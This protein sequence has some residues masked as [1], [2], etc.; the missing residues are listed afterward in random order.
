MS[1]MREK[2]G[3]SGKLFAFNFLESQ[4]NRSVPSFF[5]TSTTGDEYSEWLLIIHCLFSRSSTRC[6]NSWLSGCGKEL[7]V[8]SHGISSFNLIFI[9]LCS[10]LPISMS[11]VANT[12]VHCWFCLVL[13]WVLQIFGLRVSLW[14]CWQMEVYMKLTVLT[15]NGIT[16]LTYSITLTLVS[17]HNNC[18]CPSL[19]SPHYLL[20]WCLSDNSASSCGNIMGVF[21]SKNPTSA[22]HCTCNTFPAVT[23]MY[24]S[25]YFYRG[26]CFLLYCCYEIYRWIYILM[27]S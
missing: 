22:L 11:S 15:C 9:L 23:T 13:C 1:F 25:M 20:H 14:L 21:L 2:G 10:T 18:W 24:F 7:Y 17:L 12:G 8:A 19:L 3:Q 5:L 26:L 4:H 16:D 6:F 27:V